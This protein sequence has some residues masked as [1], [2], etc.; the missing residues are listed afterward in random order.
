[1]SYFPKPIISAVD[2]AARVFYVDRERCRMWNDN[3]RGDELRL[4]TGW[5]WI[6]RDGSGRHAQGFKTE[7][8]AYRDAWYVLVAKREVPTD[9]AKLRVVP[10]KA[11]A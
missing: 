10:K 11:V 4:L 1:M 3:R 2:E 7:S 8:V 6:A 5:C 9:S